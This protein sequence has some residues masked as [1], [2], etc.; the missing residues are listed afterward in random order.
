MTHAPSVFIVGCPRSGTSV[1]YKTLAAH[2]SFACTTNL[3]RR[4]GAQSPF[5]RLAE[6]FGAK[7]RPAE[8]GRL[9]RRFRQRG[10]RELTRDDLTDDDRR[11][12]HRLVDGHVRHFGRQVFLSK[13]PGHSLRIGWTA[14]GLPDA[15]FIHCIRDGRAVANSVLRECKKAGYRWS[16]MGREIWPELG[17]MDWAAYAGALWS[18]VTLTARAALERVDPGR[19]LEVRYRDF[20]AAPLETMAGVAEFCE[21]PWGAGLH[22]TVPRLDD[23]NRRWKDEMSADE[24]QH[25]LEQVR[26]AMETLEYS[27]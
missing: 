25:M 10:V 18:R 26:P 9:W 19:V 12:L 24:Q 15:K 23:R 27:M 16:Y 7:H 3:T 2:P 13:W 14:A 1:F 5:V 17:D 8:A 21:I 22:G 20:V 6:L 4:F 11:G